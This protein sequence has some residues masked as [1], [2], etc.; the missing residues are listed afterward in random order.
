VRQFDPATDIPALLAEAQ[1]GALLI[2]D[3]VVTIVPGDSHKNTEVR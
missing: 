2:V 1:K 3:P